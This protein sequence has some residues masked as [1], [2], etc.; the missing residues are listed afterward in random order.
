[1]TH[2][3]SAA[4]EIFRWGYAN[5][6]GSIFY[7]AR[8]L[9]LDMEDIGIISAIFYTFEAKSK[10][11]F[12]TGINTGQV[13]QCCPILTKN[14]LSRKLTKL[15]KNGIIKVV[16]NSSRTFADKTIF[17]EPL[18]DRLEELVIRDHPDFRNYQSNDDLETEINNYRHQIEQL[19]LALEEEKGKNLDIPSTGNCNYK[20]LADFIASKTGNLMS[21][22]MGTELKRWLND[23][24][25]TPEFL[26]CLLEM[27]FER[28]IYNPRQITKIASD[29]KEYSINT[30]EGLELYFNTNVKLEKFERFKEFDPEVIEF[31]DFTGIDMNA[32]ARKAIY[33]KW[34]YDWAFS[35]KMIMKAGAIM[36]QRTRNGGLEYVDS[37]LKNWM[38]KEI[39]SVEE[40]DKEM[41]EYKSRHKKEKSSTKTKKP[42]TSS[43][44]EIYVPPKDMLDANKTV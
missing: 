40:A 23:M 36:C 16:D 41:A 26:F 8:E 29:I 22:K 44:Y 21:V 1:M 6:P 38:S 7:Y 5:V 3:K 34:R 12:Q 28:K 31:G 42:D 43:D 25:F 9:D 39:R 17:F 19:Q 15:T 33:Y 2:H 14:K 37:V 32:E 20:K 11:L 4:L 18:L 27:C 35:H 30:L 24:A 10:P 13:L